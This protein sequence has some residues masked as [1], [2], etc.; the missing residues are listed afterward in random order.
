LN[1]DQQ[2]IE[3]GGDLVPSQC[4][5]TNIKRLPRGLFLPTPKKIL[6]VGTRSPS[7][8]VKEM[9][10]F[11]MTIS[12]CGALL[13]VHMRHRFSHTNI[14]EQDKVLETIGTAKDIC[15]EE[16]PSVVSHPSLPSP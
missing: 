3:N 5:A 8:E 10:L 9:L 6:L 4:S 15:K 11:N 12:D 1:D 16:W 13:L 7:V 14:T 2:K